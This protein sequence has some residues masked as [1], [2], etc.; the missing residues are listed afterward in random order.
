M[1]GSLVT[2]RAPRGYAPGPGTFDAR[3][4]WQ[5]N[6]GARLKDRGNPATAARGD[7]GQRGRHQ[8]GPEGGRDLLCAD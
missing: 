7:R 8:P 4:S 1:T 6:P 2:F 5:L 3:A